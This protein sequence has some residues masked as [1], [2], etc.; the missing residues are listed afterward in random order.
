MSVT[1]TCADALRSMHII[2]RT[3]SPPPLEERDPATLTLDELRELQKLAQRG[4]VRWRNCHHRHVLSEFQKYEEAQMKIK[5]EHI[6]DTPR[7]RKKFRPS[8]GDTQLEIDREGSFS[9]A[10]TATLAPAEHEVIELD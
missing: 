6:D 3:P 4:K 8:A 10:S 7:S 2:P 5:R 1:L 9:E